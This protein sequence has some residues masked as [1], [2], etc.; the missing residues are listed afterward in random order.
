MHVT[1]ELSSTTQQTCAVCV[2]PLQGQK[3]A[4]CW[5]GR[6][7][8]G[9]IAFPTLLPHVASRIAACVTSCK[10]YQIQGL[11]RRCKHFLALRVRVRK[12]AL[13]FTVDST[14]AL[15]LHSA[16]AILRTVFCTLNPS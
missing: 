6:T 2:E 1:V 16:S 8:H 4:N 15:E 12:A 7:M 10:T 11:L 14:P 13:T 9:R 3:V 5:L